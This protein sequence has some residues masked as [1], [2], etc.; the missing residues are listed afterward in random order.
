MRD[1]LEGDVRYRVYS[2]WYHGQFALLYMV[3]SCPFFSGYNF[4]WKLGFTWLS[5]LLEVGVV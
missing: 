3:A 1:V 5:L 4:A 2:N